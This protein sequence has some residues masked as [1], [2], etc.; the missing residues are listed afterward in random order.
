VT[1]RS[2]DER[3][4]R[5]SEGSYVHA[6]TGVLGKA[7]VKLA[8]RYLDE[9]QDLNRKPFTIVAVQ[10][11]RA[12]EQCY[13]VERMYW[14]HQGSI[15]DEVGALGVDTGNVQALI[16][17]GRLMVKERCKSVS[18]VMASTALALGTILLI[19]LGTVY[20]DDISVQFKICPEAAARIGDPDQTTLIYM[21]PVYQ[22]AMA[23]DHALGRLPVREM[24]RQPGVSFIKEDGLTIGPAGFSI[25]RR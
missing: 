5:I 3:I 19:S 22:V 12:R 13:R 17:K 10:A 2:F 8:R 7:C 1:V 4:S 15:E 9:L 21:V 20:G 18:M 16:M 6:P 25:K 23:H 14:G 11:V 24:L